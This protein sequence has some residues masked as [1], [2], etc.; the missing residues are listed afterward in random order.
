MSSTNPTTSSMTVAAGHHGYTEYDCSSYNSNNNSRRTTYDESVVS[1]GRRLTVQ[2]LLA[3]PSVR[4]SE[5]PYS[6]TRTSTPS[7][8]E[9]PNST[10]MQHYNHQATSPHHLTRYS[11]SPPTLPLPLPSQQQTQLLRI[12]PAQQQPG[13]EIDS[14]K[15]T[16]PTPLTS[17]TPG[18]TISMSS[19]PSLKKIIKIPI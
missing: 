13:M 15:L 19:V 9:P 10:I 5:S 18:P 8:T 4:S 14:F 3:E 1:P 17:P 2:E 11:Q 7:P 6:T 12:P 16:L